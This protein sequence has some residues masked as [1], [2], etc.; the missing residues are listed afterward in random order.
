MNIAMLISDELYIDG[1]SN[2]PSCIGRINNANPKV[3]CQSTDKNSYTG[4]STRFVLSHNSDQKIQK[5]DVHWFALRA[6]YGREQK[7]CDYLV[8]KNVESYCPTITTTKIV[9]GERKEVVM[10]RLPNI[11]FARG[12]EDE[13]KAYV[14]DNIHLPYLRFYY[15]YSHRNGELT[16]EPLIVPDDQIESLRIIC[17]A[18]AADV[19][20]VP[21]EVTK[22]KTGQSVRIINGPF[23]GVIGKVARYQGQQRVAII[24]KGMLTIATAYVPTSFLEQIT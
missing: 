6:T 4:V 2:S 21:S 3:L 16:K 22:F 10:S 18:E 1:E 5:R 7:A 14:Y 11:F 8:S 12:T 19:L 15:R 13:I 9:R 24:I 20:F 17:A 23:Q